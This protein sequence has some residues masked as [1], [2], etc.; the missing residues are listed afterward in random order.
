M[1][2]KYLLNVLISYIFQAKVPEG[3][4]TIVGYPCVFPFIYNNTRHIGCTAD[5]L[6]GVFWCATSV[7]KNG[8]YNGTYGICSPSCLEKS[9]SL[10]ISTTLPISS[11]NTPTITIST[12]TSA[13]TPTTIT[14]TYISTTTPT[15]IATTTATT[16]LNCLTVNGENCTFPFIY[17]GKHYGSCTTADNSGVSWCPTSL[18]KNGNVKEYDYCLKSCP[19]N[20]EVKTK[21]CKTINGNVCSFPFNYNSVKYDHCK[22]IGIIRPWCAVKTEK[23]TNE[24]IA[25]EYCNS[26]CDTDSG[27]SHDGSKG[28]F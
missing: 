23:D 11:K 17:N 5:N 19:I 6:Y 16:M 15:S 14:T 26:Q 4:S 2:M 21:E 13:T 18:T 28:T 25:W 27:P 10:N 1:Y 9:Q 24:V 20:V 22:S 3:C 12:T 7:D 8:V